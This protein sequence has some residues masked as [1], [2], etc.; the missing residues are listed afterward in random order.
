[1]KVLGRKAKA[2]TCGLTLLRVG[3]AVLTPNGFGKR[4]PSRR[5]TALHER[6]GRVSAAGRLVG[7]SRYTFIGDPSGSSAGQLFDDS[8]GEHRRIVTGNPSCEAA[9]FGGP[10]LL[11]TCSSAAEVYSLAGGSV[12]AIGTAS[13]FNG[14]NLDANA[15][16]FLAVAVGSRWLEVEER[17]GHAPTTHWFQDLE[18]GAVH[19]DPTSA[20]TSVDLNS[21]TLRTSCVDR[22]VWRRSA[23]ATIRKAGLPSGWFRDV[24]QRSKRAPVR[25]PARIANLP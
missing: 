22:C 4:L 9:A 17:D 20:T 10:R 7:S 5:S 21:A 15:C 16:P 1:M 6:F 13:I 24:S 8:T 2:I 3:G 18:T 11:F 12:S 14:C 25:P 23:S 19:L